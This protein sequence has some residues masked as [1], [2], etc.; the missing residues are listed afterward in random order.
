[1]NGT[2]TDI[3]GVRVGHAS[4]PEAGTGC[5]VVLVPPSTRA[6][7]VV[8]GGGPGS[9]ELELLRPIRSVPFINAVLLA[10]GSAFGLAAA[11]GVVQWLDERGIGHETPWATV[12]IVPAAV[13][14]D[15]AVGSKKDRPSAEDGYYACDHATGDPVEM[16]SVGAGTGATVGKWAGLQY[17]MKGGV[18]SASI[19]LRDGGIVAALVVVN[20]I[21][22]V[23][24]RGMSRILAGARNLD[25]SGYRA[26]ADG[27]FE[28]TLAASPSSAVENTTLCLVATNVALTK[29]ELNVLANMAH[30]GLARSVRPT[31]TPH[32]GDLVFALSS[33]DAEGRLLT[34][35]AAA[36]D[37][38]Q[39]AVEA[40]V[41]KAV[42]LH[43]IPGLGG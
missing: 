4:R 14:Y 9:R 41:R 17:A 28:Y 40:S 30:N 10:G 32:D 22:D 34:V 29:T 19:S 33:G 5:T 18:G 25:G 21:G 37:C 36:A 24:E 2:L 35:G 11:D 15:L 27:H 39:S 26:R 6:S 1:M 20:A 16:G 3:S 23:M 13:L 43:G 8:R 42:S 38:V 31:N 12:P 7:V